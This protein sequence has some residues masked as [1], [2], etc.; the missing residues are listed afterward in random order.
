M[1]VFELIGVLLGFCLLVSSLRLL[2]SEGWQLISNESANHDLEIE[3]FARTINFVIA[4][5]I[6]IFFVNLLGLFCTY[7]GV[8]RGMV[9]YSVVM[10]VATFGVSVYLVLAT[11][12][13]RELEE[14][15]RD[16]FR[17]LWVMGSL[18]HFTAKIET[19]FSC[20][21]WTNV[22]DHCSGP[23]MGWIM[24]EY[25]QEM[26]PISQN[27]NCCIE[28]LSF[29]YNQFSTISLKRI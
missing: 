7:G 13:S 6:T 29:R 3:K 11:H 19:M 15:T 5:A 22:F 1:F 24:H 8:Y 14:S 27:S 10:F 28:N 20:C 23:E 16:V 25:L 2:Y 21:G 9:V 4:F 26:A 17:R 12:Y 18:T